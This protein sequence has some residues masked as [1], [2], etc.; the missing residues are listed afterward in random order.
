RNGF[1]A[2]A[3]FD[4]TQFGGNEDGVLSSLDTIFG[5]LQVWVDADHNG[6]TSAGELTSLAANGVVSIEVDAKESRRKDRYGNELR[7]RARVQ[8]DDGPSSDAID[9]FFQRQ[10]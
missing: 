2:L 8:R 9:V 10:Q 3:P 5:A 1:A 4:L 6:V 7:Y